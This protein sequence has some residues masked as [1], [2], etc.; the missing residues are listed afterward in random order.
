[1]TARRRV[2]AEFVVKR[3][4]RPEKIERG[5]QVQ[6]PNAVAPPTQKSPPSP[7]G[8]GWS[9]PVPVV[10]RE[11]QQPTSSATRCTWPEINWDKAA[12]A[13]IVIPPDVSDSHK[14]AVEALVRQGITFG[15]TFGLTGLDL[16]K[17]DITWDGDTPSLKS[18]G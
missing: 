7:P 14:L 3:S 1:M 4:P 15:W 13:P 16:P 6:A 2:L 10:Y 8:R 11:P 5:G 17:V 18:R 9:E 12:R